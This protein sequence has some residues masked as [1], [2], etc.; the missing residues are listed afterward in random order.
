[1]AIKITR[2]QKHPMISPPSPAEWEHHR[3]TDTQPGNHDIVDALRR[4]HMSW[5]RETGWPAGIT[6]KPAA[7]SIPADSR[8]LDAHG[9]LSVHTL[10]QLIIRSRTA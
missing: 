8:I 3:P 7:S 5:K 9:L 1:M 2:R 10:V 6:K 4:L